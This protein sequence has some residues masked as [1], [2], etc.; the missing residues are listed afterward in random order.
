MC[1]ERTPAPTSHAQINTSFAYSF[2][3]EAANKSAGATQKRWNGMSQ[4]KD[5]RLQLNSCAP[6]PLRN[7]ACF[8]V[9]STAL[10]LI[11]YR[12]RSCWQPD[13]DNKI[14]SITGAPRRKCDHAIWHC[15]CVWPGAKSPKFCYEK[16][17]RTRRYTCTTMPPR[18]HKE[19]PQTHARTLDMMRENTSI[20]CSH[21]S[22]HG[23]RVLHFF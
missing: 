4:R 11:R 18:V 6:I 16:E 20:Y 14:R 2:G 13:T 21:Q 22:K 1:D 3:T 23:M 8:A 12:W 7:S 10:N 5:A 19:T 15:A 9:C 17:K